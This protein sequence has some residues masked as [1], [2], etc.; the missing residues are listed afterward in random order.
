MLKTILEE[1]GHSAFEAFE[2][3]LNWSSNGRDALLDEDGSTD[4][5]TLQ[6][7]ILMERVVD[8][9][10]DRIAEAAQRFRNVSK[11]AHA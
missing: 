4:G 11:E 2:D 5:H 1:E 7:G 10:F 8:K 3:R 9:T 6:E